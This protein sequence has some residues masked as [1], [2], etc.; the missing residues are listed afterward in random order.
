MSMRTERVGGEIRK[1]LADLLT[2]GDIKDYR[3]T[4]II[5]IT[6]IEVSGDLRHARVYFSLIGQ[7]DEKSAAAH[8][9]GLNHAAGYIQRQVARRLRLR[10]TPLMQFELDGSFEYAEHI[11]RLLNALDIPPEEDGRE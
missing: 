4:G 11:G 2:R 1:V 8:Q 3:L 10:R 5:N 7:H 9:E 6:D